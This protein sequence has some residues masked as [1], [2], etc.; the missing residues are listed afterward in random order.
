MKSDQNKNIS[1][2]DS[3]VNVYI[4]PTDEELMMVWIVNEINRI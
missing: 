3:G 4:I 1:A 2:N